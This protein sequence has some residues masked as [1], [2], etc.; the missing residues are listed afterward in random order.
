M[1]LFTL[2]FYPRKEGFRRLSPQ[3]FTFYFYFLS[4]IFYLSRRQAGII[5]PDPSR[6]TRSPLQNWCCQVPD[7]RLVSTNAIANLGERYYDIYEIR[8]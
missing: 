3:L 1:Q 2:N 4:F 5:Y 6:N 7:L 8:V